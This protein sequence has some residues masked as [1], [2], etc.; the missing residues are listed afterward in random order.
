MTNFVLKTP[1]V[2]IIFNRPETTEKVFIEIAKAR[3]QKLLVISDGPRVNRPGEE[4]RVAEAR[5]IINRVDWPCE[6]FC[7]FS[8]INLGCKVRVSS[9]LDWAF[10]LVSEAIIL[11]DDCLPD[12]T[13]FRFCEELLAEYREDKR[14]GMISGDNFQF[15]RLY[16]E[17]SY[18][19]SKYMHIWGWATWKDRW[20]NSY[21]VNM[22][23]WP[24]AR[25]SD[26]LS[27]IFENKRET[28]FWT[29]IFDKVYRGKIDTW[30]Y[31]WAYANWI[32]NRCSVLPSV[33]LISNIGF[34]ADA[35]HTIRNSHLANLPT[36]SLSFP[37][38]HPKNIVKNDMADS[39]TRKSW[40]M[41]PLWLKISDRI[42]LISVKSLKR[43]LTRR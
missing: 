3:P 11:E 34:G 33:N 32:R 4:L 38:T 12:P 28:N 23:D 27:K 20:V 22:T 31:Q 8:D 15:G 24:I 5:S 16:N 40:F 6:V 25:D 43:S 26:R 1:I 21:D 9:G 37:L 14:I 35:T 13:F 30:D 18:Y 2:F 17:D 19:F 29:S 41:R 7:D 10:E 42:R 39:F 36:K